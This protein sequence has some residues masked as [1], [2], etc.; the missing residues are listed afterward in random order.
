M[1]VHR[2]S[3]KYEKEVDKFLQFA[4]QNGKLINGTI[5]CPHAHCLN[6]IYQALREIHYH[7]FFFNI[8]KSYTICIKKY[9]MFLLFPKQQKLSKQR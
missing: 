8:L 2:I 4:H 1:N 7:L 6:Q 9:Y 5:Y 3:V